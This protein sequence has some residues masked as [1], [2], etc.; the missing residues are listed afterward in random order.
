MAVIDFIK[1]NATKYLPQKKQP[2]L[3]IPMSSASGGIGVGVASFDDE[4]R[5][6]HPNGSV[7]ESAHEESGNDIV[8]IIETGN[9][10]LR[11][12]DILQLPRDVLLRIC[13]VVPESQ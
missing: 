13:R 8:A 12:P 1:D 7:F 4:V 10:L 2:G 6:I 9:R 11:A 3:A 5:L